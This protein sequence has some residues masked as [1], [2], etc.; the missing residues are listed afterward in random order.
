LRAL[1]EDRENNPACTYER[2]LLQLTYFWFKEKEKS[3]LG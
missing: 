1:F 2:I 3:V